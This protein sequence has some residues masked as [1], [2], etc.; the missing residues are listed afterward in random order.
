MKSPSYSSRYIIVVAVVALAFAAPLVL[1]KI[2]FDG[3]IR[4]NLLGEDAFKQVLQ[5]LMVTVLGG[6]LF[7]G[8]NARKE[9]QAR[10]DAR[11]VK[12]QALDDKLGE[13][14]RQIKSSK[15]RLR[16]RLDRTN[17]EV[18]RIAKSE[19]EE[20]MDQLLA[21]QIAI[22]EVQDVI[23]TRRDLIDQVVMKR[24]DKSLR[25]VARYLHDVFEDFEKAR[26]MREPDSYVLTDDAQN[27]RDFLLKSTEDHG[28][29]NERQILED[30][31]RPFS[32]RHDALDRIGRLRT[33]RSGRVA[34]A[35]VR[36]TS[37]ELKHL[38]DAELIQDA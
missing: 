4:D 24:I 15:R 18:P 34:M 21:T 10:R 7:F 35:C 31:H 29:T 37:S 5:F 36:L 22:E 33:A 3:K 38:I 6:L 13:A 16:S 1:D 12:L 2:A 28:T 14:Y 11:L 17:R 26:I 9:K 19:F 32:E 20:C 30:E 25:Y 8:L 27:L 23:A